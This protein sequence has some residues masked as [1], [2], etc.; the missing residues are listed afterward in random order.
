MLER[1][2]FGAPLGSGDVSQVASD[3]TVQSILD[4]KH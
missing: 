2:S 4:G 1:A 3:A